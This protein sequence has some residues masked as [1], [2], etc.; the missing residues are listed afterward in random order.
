[1]GVFRKVGINV[2]A[3]PLYSHGWLGL[4]WP[5]ASAMDNL[6]RVDVAVHEWIGLLIYRLS[7]YSNEWF[8]GP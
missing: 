2:I 6:R 7:G 1:M 8:A 3:F 5:A 4:W